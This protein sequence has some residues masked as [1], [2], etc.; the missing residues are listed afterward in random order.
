[1]LS[2]KYGTFVST[3]LKDFGNLSVNPLTL[4]LFNCLS[5]DKESLAVV[6]RIVSVI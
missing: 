1:M 3:L 6:S 4:Y 2:D 5:I